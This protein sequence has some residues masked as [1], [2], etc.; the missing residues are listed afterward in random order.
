MFCSKCGTDLPK[1][2]RLCRK[3]GYSL[4]AAT[5][6]SVSAA[7]ARSAVA[8]APVQ[9]TPKAVRVSFVLGLLLA[10]A[11]LGWVAD[12]EAQKE[13][14]AQAA[15]R[16]QNP[17][18]QMHRITIGKGA[19]TVNAS[20]F[21]FFAMP[22]PTGATNVRVQGHFSAT[23]GSGNDIEVYLVDEDQFTNWK[24]GHETPKFYS[25]GKV[26]VGDVNVTLPDDAATYYLVF[27][28]RFSWLS[29][30]AVQENLVM[31]YY[32]RGS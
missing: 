21:T 9:T 12:H 19:L 14:A 26:T 16:A 3:C 2:S 23:G 27:D 32:S 29:P 7:G 31:T 6:E 20:Q 1:D 30:K 24:N 10:L 15:F 17:P 5:T 22:A 11:L 18:V 25:S 28:N 8:I 4:Q 13:T